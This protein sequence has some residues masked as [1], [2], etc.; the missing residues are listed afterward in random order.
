[1][2]EWKTPVEVQLAEEMDKRSLR[3]YEAAAGTAGILP[4]FHGTV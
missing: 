2:G 1:M 3:W 4:A